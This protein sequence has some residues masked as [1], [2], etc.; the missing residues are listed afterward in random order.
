MVAKCGERLHALEAMQ[1]IHFHHIITGDESCFYLEYQ[2]VSQWSVSRDEVTE[3]VDP[4]FGTA[5]FVL[6]AIWG[7]NG[8]RLRDL[9]PS[10]CK[11]NT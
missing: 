6:K 11:F 8:F 4:A 5:R 2:H 7:V 3:K 9:M 1:R 10:E